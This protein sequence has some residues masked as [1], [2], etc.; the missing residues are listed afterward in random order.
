MCHVMAAL[1][2]LG[3][4]TW[5]IFIVV[6]YH[7]NYFSFEALSSLSVKEVPNIIE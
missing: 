3:I 4:M 2:F 6:L 1:S 5:G 7:W